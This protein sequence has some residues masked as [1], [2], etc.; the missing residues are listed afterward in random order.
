MR[1]LIDTNV[2][3]DVALAR[4]PWGKTSKAVLKLCESGIVQGFVAWHTFSNLYYYVRR[5]QGRDPRVFIELC[6]RFLEVAPV[7][8][9]DLVLALKM[10][11]SDFEDAMQ[12]AAAAACGAD[13]IVTRNARDFKRS[14]I[15]AVTPKGLLREMAKDASR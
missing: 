1:V 8:T 2:L 3:V 4:A 13:R 6:L 9:Q 12:A 5:T 14:P 15:P 11:M 10:P 7:G